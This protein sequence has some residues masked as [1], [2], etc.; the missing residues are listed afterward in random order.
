[1]YAISCAFACMLMSCGSRVVECCPQLNVIR[2]GCSHHALGPPG[3]SNSRTRLRGPIFGPILASL[4]PGVGPNPGSRRPRIR[5]GRRQPGL[6][7][8]PG[9]REAK[10]G[11]KMGPRSRVR[12]LLRPGGPNACMCSASWRPGYFGLRIEFP[13]R[14]V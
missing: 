9:G 3:L 5:R 4:P 12:L 7:P 11:P 8:T 13:G 6:G 2:K 1:M 10:I 14:R